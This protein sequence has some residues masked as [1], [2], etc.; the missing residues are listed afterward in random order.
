MAARS[1]GRAE[2][3]GGSSHPAPS[4]VLDEVPALDLPNLRL[5]GEA[6]K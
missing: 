3:G 4:L 1:G 2:P 6:G 5:S